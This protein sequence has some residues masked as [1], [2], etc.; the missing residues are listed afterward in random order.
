MPAQQARTRI[1]SAGEYRAARLDLLAREKE[2]TRLRDA[3]AAERRR[4]PWVRL[5]QSYEFDGPAG[6]VPMRDLFDGRSQLIV[7]HFMLA[8]GWGEGCPLCSFWADS[9]NVMPVHLAQRDTSFVAVSRASFGEI[10]A[11][12]RR[13]GWSFPWYSSAPGDFNSD[14]GVSATP[15]QR[16]EGGEYNFRHVE[17]LGEESPGLS[18]FATN[19]TGEIFHTYSTYSRGLDPINSGYQLLDLTPKGRDEQDLRWPMAWVRR[20]DSY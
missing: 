1:S 20:H 7:Y 9:F 14:F 3:V 17:Q 11:Y 13:M 6:R 5:E 10:D 4:L 8:P 15:Q 19:E 16:A 2:L 18:V 12:R